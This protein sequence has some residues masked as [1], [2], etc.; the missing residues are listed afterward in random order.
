VTLAALLG[1]GHVEQLTLALLVIVEE[2][3]AIAR[4]VMALQQPLTGSRPS[5]GLLAAAFDS[6]AASPGAAFDELVDGAAR[7]GG[8]IVLRGD[9]LPLVERRVALSSPVHTVLRGL[10]TPVA[11]VSFAAGPAVALPTSVLAQAAAHASAF[12]ADERALVVRTPSPAEGRAACAVMAAAIGGQAAFVEGDPAAGLGLWLTMRGL[13]PVFVY[14]LGPSE[15]RRLPGLPGYDGPVLALVGLEGS[16]DRDGI[17][18]PAWRLGVPTAA[19][20]V[21]LWRHALDDEALANQLAREHRWRSDR[22]RP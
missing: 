2:D 6:V 20:R 18:V 3:P 19:E 17:A 10:T 5:V 4:L 14:D 21:A 11:A 13:V 9:E 16:I 22:W 7:A 1:L 8:A 12:S 15:R